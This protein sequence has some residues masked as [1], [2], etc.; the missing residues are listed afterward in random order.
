M[1][2]ESGHILL[3]G[4]PEGF[5]AREVAADLQA[6]VPEILRV[7]HIHA[8]AITQE[9]PNATMEIEVQTGSNHSEVKS[10]AKARLRHQFGIEH[11]TME[12]DE[13]GTME[14]HSLG[15]S[16]HATSDAIIA[17]TVG[18]SDRGA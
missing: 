13:R 7:H 3:E 1:V 8:W 11:V 12:I 16:D 5:D 9:R 15:F 4:A 17:G 10:A 6:H 18:T 14:E 2:K